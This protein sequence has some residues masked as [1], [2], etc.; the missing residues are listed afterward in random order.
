MHKSH[1]SDLVLVEDHIGDAVDD[2]V[3][4]LAI[5]A[6]QL[7]LDDMCLH[8][9]GGTSRMMRCNFLKFSSFSRYSAVRSL[10]KLVSP[11]SVTVL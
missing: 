9:G 7:P 11:I 6:H 2:G 1:G 10:G 5:G 3:L 8:V 4:S